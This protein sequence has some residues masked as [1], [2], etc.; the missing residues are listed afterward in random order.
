MDILRSEH[1][2]LRRRQ[3]AEI[4]LQDRGDLMVIAGLGATAWDITAVGD[5]PLN[6]PLWGAMGGATLIGLG[7]ALA[8]PEKRVLVLTGD[9]EMLMGLGGLATVAV[10]QP[11][12]LAIAVIDNERYGETGMQVTHT[13]Y[14]VDLTGIAAATGLPVTQTVTNE[15]QLR[16][17][18]PIIRQAPGP[19]FVTIKVRAEELP[20]ALPPKDG[21]H[22]KDRFRI[23]LLGETAAVGA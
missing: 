21:V 9:G 13:A 19:V 23:A 22:L 8:Q 12:N 16:D 3:V 11:R 4:L 1:Y 6:L 15:Q 14:D 2:S 18:V 10:K 20:L 17:A 7:L 5:H